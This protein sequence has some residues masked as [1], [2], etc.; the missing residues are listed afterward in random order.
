MSYSSLNDAFNI[1]SD[2]EKTIRGL[3]NFNPIN[4]TMENVKM[5]QNSNYQNNFYNP[6]DPI[7]IIDGMYSGDDN[8]SWESLNGTDLYSGGDNISS[9]NKL[10]HRECIKIYNN[11]DDYKDSILS[12]ALKHVSKC[13]MCKDEIK[14]S[15]INNTKTENNLKNNSSK[16]ES[17]STQKSKH[18]DLNNNNNKSNNNNTNNDNLS[19]LS[20]YKN[21]HNPSNSGSLNLSSQSLPQSLSQSQSQSQSLSQSQ[22]QSLSQS[23][24]NSKIESELKLLSD[25]INGE[26]NLKYQNAL[27]QNNISKYLE[28]LEE[29]KKINNK[30]DNILEILRLEHNIRQDNDKIKSNSEFKDNNLIN[31]LSSPQFLLNLSKINDKNTIT[32][33]NIIN[34]TNSNW[35]ESYLLYLCIFVVIVLL[36]IDIVLRINVK[37]D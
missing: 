6:N 4:N 37:S 28:D 14:K 1:N 35:S 21:F 31:L 10:T 5:S 27:I 16:S 24:S 8:L 23:Q 15:L 29:R 7:S 11:P 26:N 2:F 18:N 36:I 32:Q 19:L 12:Q 3:N 34:K 30:L 25:K 17:R 22:S 20:N 9:S 33:D 13:K